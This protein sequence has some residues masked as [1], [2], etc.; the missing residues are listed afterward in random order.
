MTSSEAAGL[1]GIRRKR[2]WI[3]FW[4]LSSV[5]LAWLV[6]RAFRS[7]VAGAVALSLWAIGSAISVARGISSR[8]PRCG[9]P[10]FSAH[11]TPAIRNLFAG[12]CMQCGLPLKPERIIYPSLE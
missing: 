3:W 2:G 1:H 6:G 11:G 10:F 12:K 5:P 4:I 9:G 7:H 8:C